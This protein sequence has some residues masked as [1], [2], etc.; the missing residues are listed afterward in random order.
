MASK[1]IPSS[2]FASNAYSTPKI[3]LRSS[4]RACFFAA[5][6][7]AEPDFANAWMS[8]AA[9][10]ETHACDQCVLVLLCW[11]ANFSPSLTNLKDLGLDRILGDELE[12]AHRLALAHLPLAQP[13][14]EHTRWTRST[15]WASIALC[16]HGS[17]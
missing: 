9:C 4:N 12:H 3:C 1:R 2:P 10:T 13:A 8:V 6:V 16:H 7:S 15:A 11:S 17:H 5:F 14:S